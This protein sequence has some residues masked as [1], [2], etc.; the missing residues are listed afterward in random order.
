MAPS[1]AVYL[2]SATNNSPTISYLVV[3]T[4]FTFL[5][6]TMLLIVAG[7]DENERRITSKKTDS[8]EYGNYILRWSEMLPAWVYP[9]CCHNKED[10]DD[11]IP[12]LGG[13][14]SS[15]KVGRFSSAFFHGGMFGSLTEIVRGGYSRIISLRVLT[16]NK[17]DMGGIS[18]S[19]RELLGR[20]LSIV[21]LTAMSSFWLSDI[22]D[23]NRNL[24]AYSSFLVLGIGHFCL[25]FASTPNEFYVS[26]VVFG[27]GEGL[28]CGLRALVKQDYLH[29]HGPLREIITKND[30]DDNKRKMLRRQINN[31]ISIWTDMT[32]LVD[33]F[34]VGFIG[35]YA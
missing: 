23:S 10:K 18:I 19:N 1:A 28:S 22:A 5:S 26:A 30:G 8:K 24:A 2:L 11:N 20:I 31:K 4:L 3:G 27:I 9:W 35:S 16:M 14:N 25:S 13:K 29:E 34:V 33:S 7:V 17:R 12:L 32:L 15:C 6:V 21:G